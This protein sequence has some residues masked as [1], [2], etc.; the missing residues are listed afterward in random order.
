[1][2]L[3]KTVTLLAAITLPVTTL[4]GCNSHGS[5]SSPD[6]QINPMERMDKDT[7][8]EKEKMKRMEK[9]MKKDK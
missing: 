4:V 5:N 9:E 2:K 3:I 8:K 1:M 7:V 6:Y